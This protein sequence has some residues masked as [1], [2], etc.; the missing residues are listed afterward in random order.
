MVLILKVIVIL[1]LYEGYIYMLVQIR[2]ITLI[3]THKLSH[4]VMS[5]MDKEMSQSKN[6]LLDVQKGLFPSLKGGSR[7]YVH[8]VVGFTTTCTISAHHH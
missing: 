3:A 7:C 1:C 2:K 8:M 5:T 4:L 6:V